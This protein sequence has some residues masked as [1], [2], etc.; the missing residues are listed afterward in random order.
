MAGTDLKQN[1]G[2]I[3]GHI[4]QQMPHRPPAHPSRFQNHNGKT[5]NQATLM[6]HKK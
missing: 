6:S 2:P 4:P 3:Q 5:F 1:S